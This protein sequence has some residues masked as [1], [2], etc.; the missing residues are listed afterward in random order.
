MSASL[1]AQRLMALRMSVSDPQRKDGG[2]YTFDRLAEEL[3]RR[4]GVGSREY[5]SAVL[6]GKKANPSM[7][8][9]YGL[10]E[11]L[12]APE[13]YLTVSDGEA[14]AFVAQVAALREQIRMLEQESRLS[15]DRLA[16]LRAYDDMDPQLR[17]ILAEM[18]RRMAESGEA[19]R[20]LI[21]EPGDQ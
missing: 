6:H 17:V 3:K 9:V 8:V 15:P 7:Q 11:I 2:I 18:A 4:T 10:A 12:G 16:L 13:G 14:K 21:V 1:I 19:G 5:V 20:P